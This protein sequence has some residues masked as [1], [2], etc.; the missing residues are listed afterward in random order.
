MPRNEAKAN[1]DANDNNNN[2]NDND[3]AN[4]DNDDANDDNDDANDDYNHANCSARQ[5]RNH[6][7]R[8]RRSRDD[9]TDIGRAL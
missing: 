8:L 4:D 6:T 3:N 2:A 5:R 1:H 7:E 9:G